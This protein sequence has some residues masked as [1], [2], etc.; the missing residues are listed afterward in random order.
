MSPAAAAELGSLLE[1]VT[2]SAPVEELIA[3]D[4]EFHRR[5]AA[6]AGNPVLAALIDSLSLPAARARMWRDMADP[7]TRQR[8]LA[9]HWAIHDAIVTGRPDVAHA[10]A[11]SHI[12]GVGQ[13]WQA[14]GRSPELAS[15]PT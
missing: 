1:R 12:A 9:E 14:H 3:N 6:A 8:T 15:V 11:T 4:L 2:A 10:W 13:S 7:S 5:I